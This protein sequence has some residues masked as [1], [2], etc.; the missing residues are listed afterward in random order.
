MSTSNST[1][2]EILAASLAHGWAGDGSGPTSL[3]LTRDDRPRED[4]RVQVWFC[5]HRRPGRDP[6]PGHISHAT[7]T[8][9][10][11]LT[12]IEGRHKAAQVIKELSR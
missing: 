9:G 10:T 3:N 5:A 8:R 12:R 11:R 7:V 4:R 2:S 6:K 1:Y